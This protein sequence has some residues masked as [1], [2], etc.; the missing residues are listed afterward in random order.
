MNT[1]I[2]AQN[3]CHFDEIILL[4][5][6]IPLLKNKAKASAKQRLD[7]LQLAINDFPQYPFTI[8][9]REI[10]RD[11][12]SFM[13]TTLNDFRHQAEYSDCAITLMIGMDTFLQLPKWHQWETILSLTNLL[14]I[15][16]PGIYHL[17]SILS[18]LIATH[19]TQKKDDL[20]TTS[21]GLIYRFNAGYY[22]VS[23]TIIR[24]HI[25]QNTPCDHLL[26]QGVFDY[27][28]NNKLYE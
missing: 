4:P 7:M 10:T 2:N 19:Q 26:T 24:Q 27:I 25:Q 3:H 13:V 9:T 1:V 18:N 23:S 6:K 20:A 12:P 5:C 15:N 22:E 11:S 16:R 17:P 28:R 8:D 21:H 14:I